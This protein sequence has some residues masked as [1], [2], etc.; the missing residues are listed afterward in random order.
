MEINN[1][2]VR[3]IPIKLFPN[4][5]SK[6]TI[7]WAHS[8]FQYSHLFLDHINYEQI[9]GDGDVEQWLTKSL[10]IRKELTDYGLHKGKEY[11]LYVATKRFNLRFD[12]HDSSEPTSVDDVVSIFG[13]KKFYNSDRSQRLQQLYSLMYGICRNGD[14]MWVLEAEQVKLSKY[15]VSYI[16]LGKKS[17]S[18]SVHGR[19]CFFN[20]MKINFSQQIT[21]KFQH[22]MTTQHG[23]YL[24]VRNKLKGDGAKNAKKL[25][26]PRGNV[27]LISSKD[28]LSGIEN[29][30]TVPTN[31][32]ERGK[33]WIQDCVKQGYNES[34]LRDMVDKLIVNSMSV[35]MG[36]GIGKFQIICCC[37]FIRITM[38]L[39][40]LFLSY[41]CKKMMTN[42]YQ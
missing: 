19:G 29:T 17:Y 16:D 27:W 7:E 4:R 11:L 6:Y 5:E 2:I 14:N 31:L 12:G 1:D 42:L 9:R 26:F 18:E 38:T 28:N 41:F 22:M 10:E 23:E 25:F 36:K 39:I 33:E 13:N 21:R 35:T 32:E 15:R 24:N 8:T 34:R 30:D 3:V 20:V 37:K 40:M